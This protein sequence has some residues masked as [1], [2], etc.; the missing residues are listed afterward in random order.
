MYTMEKFSE[1][2]K[3]NEE[4]TREIVTLT[5]VNAEINVSS[6]SKK[7]I[8]KSSKH[9]NAKVSKTDNIQKI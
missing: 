5:T 6:T 1:I 3:F 2:E 8:S 7:E 4:T 9:L